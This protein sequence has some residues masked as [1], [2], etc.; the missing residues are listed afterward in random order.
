M[1]INV[2]I[3]EG[4]ENFLIS[5]LQEDRIVFFWQARAIDIE[6]HSGSVLIEQLSR[7]TKVGEIRGNAIAWWHSKESQY[8]SRTLF[9]S[10]L[11]MF[12]N[13]IEKYAWKPINLTHYQSSICNECLDK[14]CSY[15]PS[16]NIFTI[17]YIG[18]LLFQAPIIHMFLSSESRCLIRVHISMKTSQTSFSEQQ[19]KIKTFY[20]Y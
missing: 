6:N 5:I 9:S 13:F 7:K 12:L 8:S 11:I 16:L 14:L 17:T 10:S 18:F 15:Y 2:Q 4:V 19:D 1:V 20:L 3:N